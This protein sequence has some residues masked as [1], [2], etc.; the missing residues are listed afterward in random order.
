MWSS[1]K[2]TNNLIKHI[3]VKKCVKLKNESLMILKT[4][5][6]H[7]QESNTLADQVNTTN[8]II[9]I[10]ISNDMMQDMN[11][12]LFPREIRNQ[13]NITSKIMYNYSFVINHREFNLS[14]VTHMRSDKVYKYC[15]LVIFLLQ[16]IIRFSSDKCCEKLDIIIFL[17]NSKKILPSKGDIF[18]PL[19]INSGFT[20]GGCNPYNKIVIFR[21][22]EWFKVL[23]H[24]CMHAFKLDYSS[25]N[26][27]LID[28]KIQTTFPI[29]NVNI[30]SFESY[31]EVWAII[32]NCMFHA[33]FKHNIN[34]GK[35]T[36]LF[37]S[38]YSIECHFSYYQMIKILKHMK[39]NYSDL[40]NK[41]KLSIYKRNALYK[42]NTSVF[43][44]FVLKT[45]LL[46]NIN[47]FLRFC[48][49]N[50][51]DNPIRFGTK[52]SLLIGYS[53]LIEKNYK[54]IP[55]TI[56]SIKYSDIARSLKFSVFDLD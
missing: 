42:E 34:F 36:T 39:L 2:V 11:V 25:L 14:F 6:R 40:H 19:H 44:Y 20:R 15:R 53:S 21:K 29:D 51:E 10:T 49:Q 38:I 54:N 32:L 43:S 35:F 46:Q 16:F 41:D 24:E 33:Y 1:G 18:S 48:S 4:L 13:I 47:D 27:E 56:D 26:N 30:K 23:I 52:Q 12:D 50:K 5:F 8:K 22:E 28:A 3:E 37:K 17:T 7:Y 45:I 9:D 31:C 55:H